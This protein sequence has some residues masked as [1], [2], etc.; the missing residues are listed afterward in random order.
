MDLNDAAV[1]PVVLS[2]LDTDDTPFRE[3]LVELLLL[4]LTVRSELATEPLL[5]VC[6]GL[7]PA[8]RTDDPDVVCRELPL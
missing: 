8:T 3:M 2:C 5:T 7:S 1:L 4:T 6:T